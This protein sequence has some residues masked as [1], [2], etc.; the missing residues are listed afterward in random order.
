MTTDS[1]PERGGGIR[2]G[3]RRSSPRAFPVSR[4]PRALRFG[5]MARFSAPVIAGR[6]L[7]EILFLLAVFFVSWGIS[8]SASDLDCDNASNIPSWLKADC[9]GLVKLYKA[10]GG[11]TW[12]TSTNWNTDTS[13]GSWHGVTVAAFPVNRVTGVRLDKNS[14]SGT[15]PDLSDLAKLLSLRLEGNSLSGTIPDLSTQLTQ[16]TTLRLDDN[17]LNGT[18]TSASFPSS[19]WYLQLHGNSLSGEIPDLSN[20]SNLDL[21]YLND[22][23]FSGTITA[24]NFPSSLT[25]LRLHGNGLSGEIPDLS[26]QLTSLNILRL[27]GNSLS[28]KITATDFPTSLTDLR[29]N[30]N[31]ISGEIPD[32]STRFTS[33][34]TLVLND[35]SLSGTVDPANFPSSLWYLYLHRNSLSG[36]IPTSLTNFLNLRRLLLHGNRLSGVIPGLEFGQNFFYLQYLYLSDNELTGEIPS[37]LQYVTALTHLYLDNN[38]L[39]G[40]IPEELQYLGIKYL[41]LHGNSLSG[42]IPEEL[43]YLVDLIHLSLHSNSLSGEIPEDF[44][45]LVKLERMYLN[46]NKLSG[47]IPEELQYLT[48]LKHLYL[49][50]NKL[51]GEI[52]TEL[53]DLTSLEHLYLNDN[54]LSGEI[55]TELEDLTKLTRL[56]LQNNQL[57]GSGDALDTDLDELE[58]LQELALWGNAD[59]TGAVDLHGSVTSGVIDRAALRVLYDTNSGPDWKE[60]TGWLAALPADLGTWYGVTTGSGRVTALDLSANRL[61]NP[62]SKS[63]EALDGLTTLNLSD[64]ESLAGELPARLKDVSGLSSVNI[65]CTD[66]ETPSASDFQ[67]WLSALSSFLKGCPGSLTVVPGIQSLTVSWAAATGA[68]SYKVQWKS[69]SQD[70]DENARQETVT[71]GSATA[72][73]TGLAGGTEHTVRVIATKKTGGDY[74]EP[75]EEVKGTPESPPPPPP[76][77]PP[78]SAPEPSTPVSPDGSVLIAGTGDGFAFTP[79]GGAGS[80]TWGTKT[81]EFTVTGND[82]LSPN[83]TIILSRTALS[84]VADAAGNVTFD[85]SADLSGDPPSGFRLGGLVADIGLGVDDAG[86]TVGVCLPADAEAEGP[87]VHRY[88]EESG[89]WEPLAEQETAVL[90]GVRSVCGKTDAVARFGLFVTV[91]PVTVGEGGGGGCAVAGAGS[92]GSASSPADLLSAGLLLL[93]AV[94]F[95][96]RTLR[97]RQNHLERQAVERL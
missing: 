11:A 47:E 62:V 22:N 64:N 7:R 35:N 86:D 21:L 32:L 26:T 55:P 84:A 45:Y 88:D 27:G 25:D 13:L 66:V 70:W 80:V 79:V 23:S 44:R 46:G 1:H 92:G 78:P 19:L 73:I 6:R 67:N 90:N 49:N 40:E 58:S 93:A 33:L 96:R 31:S 28:G 17:S 60:N 87:V 54:K 37:D 20:I 56:Y 71:D 57:S 10:T 41:S 76:P 94:S 5:A 29:L 81:V 14:L 36:E 9:K 8:A 12:K 3:L 85:I 4:F 38:K 91:P 16:L 82:G 69:G 61:R 95:R 2:F 83:P 97:E 63:L 51:S 18:I 77:P 52:P 39:S 89:R 30:G 75:S 53:G 59:P 72:T 65:Q 50:D 43:Q 74:R 15:I 68:G 24:A 48:E 34:Y 42:E